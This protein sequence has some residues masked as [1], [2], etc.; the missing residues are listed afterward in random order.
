MDTQEA[1]L[2]EDWSYED[3]YGFP[4]DEELT[5]LANEL[6]MMLDEEERSTN[7]AEKP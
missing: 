2:S 3:D 7:L 5:F 4:S 1:P 6:F